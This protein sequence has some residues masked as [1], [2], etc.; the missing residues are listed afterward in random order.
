MVSKKKSKEQ[1]Y[2]DFGEWYLN[3]YEGRFYGWPE[4]YDTLVAKKTKN[5]D[6]IIA[7]LGHKAETFHEGYRRAEE[8]G[9]E[10]AF[11]KMFD[12]LEKIAKEE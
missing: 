7:Y 6:I 1:Q 11:V 4:I 10:D 3:Y 8:L 12:E 2:E 5:D 9:K